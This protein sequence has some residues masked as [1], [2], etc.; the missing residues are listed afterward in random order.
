MGMMKHIY[1]MKIREK[2]RRVEV[3]KNWIRFALKTCHNDAGK[4]ERETS[5]RWKIVRFS[6]KNIIL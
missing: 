3:R 2:K 4:T 6:W 5:I 1:G